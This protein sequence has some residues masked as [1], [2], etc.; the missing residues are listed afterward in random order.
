[1]KHLG[2]LLEIKNNDPLVYSKHDYKNILMLSYYRN[3]LAHVF[4]NEAYIAC[5]LVGFGEIII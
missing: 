5:T 4:I 2:D 1:M 3:N